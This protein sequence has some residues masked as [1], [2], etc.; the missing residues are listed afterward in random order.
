MKLAT[1]DTVSLNLYYTSMIVQ[2]YARVKDYL[3]KTKLK[4][5][6]YVINPYVGCPHQCLYCYASY[7][8]SFS[9]HAE[10]WGNFIDVK[11]TNKKI[12][13]FKIK[14]KKVQISTVTDPYN[15]FEAEFKVTRKIMEQLVKSEALISVCT[16]S[17]LVL[18]DVDLFKQMKNLEVCISISVLD[19][20][21]K[22][23]LEP[24][25]PSIKRR[26]EAL[27]G[28]KL[29]GIKTVC[30]VSPLIPEITDYEGI[31]D[32]A[33]DY[34]DEFRFDKLDLRT[35]FK[36]KMFN[37]IKMNFSELIPLYESIYNEKD[38]DYFEKIANDIAT[39]C[40]KNNIKYNIN[41]GV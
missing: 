17:D 28:L 15:Y 27:K 12:N 3:N 40:I 2:D 14:D 9:K 34:V 33:K 39:Y 16:K 20:N 23:R 38:Y 26:I 1:I 21:L 35:T 19:E 41:I 18:R 32:A 37:F 22:E 31:I 36:T 7:M 11:C 4:S 10:S 5:L 29:E 25:S 13:T 24:N 8:S 30:S 6:D